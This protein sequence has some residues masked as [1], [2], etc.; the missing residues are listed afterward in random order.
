MKTVWTL[1]SDSR[2]EES[3]NKVNKPGGSMENVLFGLNILA[4]KHLYPLA[5]QITIVC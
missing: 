2:F 1:T 4:G 5:C 3:I